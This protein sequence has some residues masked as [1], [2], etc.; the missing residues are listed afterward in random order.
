MKHFSI[1]EL[2]KSATAS[3][4][5]IDNTPSVQ[6]VKNLTELV[7][8]ILDPLREAWGAPIRVSSG[9]RSTMLNRAVGGVPSSQHV[10]G[11]AA[12]IT[13]GSRRDN[14]RLFK[15][16]QSMG[17]PFDQLIFEKG[18]RAVGPDWVHVSYS[19]VRRRGQIL[20]VK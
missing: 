5:R 3:S 18:D 15:L 4:R 12:D 6:V 7:R 20:F 1:Q 11:E 2:C 13:V 16:V 19:T 9:Y 8:N 17:L 14:M 10:K